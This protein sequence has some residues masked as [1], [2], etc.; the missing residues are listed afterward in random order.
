MKTCSES[1]K[2]ALTMRIK[3]DHDFIGQDVLTVDF[4]EFFQF[5]NL[6]ALDK[7]LVACYCL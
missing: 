5:Y 7:S 4:D 6:K 3:D 1:G 2:D